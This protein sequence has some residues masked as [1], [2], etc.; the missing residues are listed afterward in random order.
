MTKGDKGY[1][2]TVTICGIPYKV[3]LTEDV[4]DATDRHLGQIDYVKCE[5]RVNKEL[6]GEALKETIAHEIVHG[7]LFHLGYSSE[8]QN[9]QLVQALGNAI[10][11]TFDIKEL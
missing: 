10:N 5:I 11:Q 7:M 4:F 1:M 8:S 2:G 9:E 6:K 3:I